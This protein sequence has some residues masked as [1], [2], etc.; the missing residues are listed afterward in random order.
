MN[1]HPNQPSLV[2]RRRI[3][4]RDTEKLTRHLDSFQQHMNPFPYNLPL[5]NPA[6]GRQLRLSRG[7]L[8]VH[9]RQAP[10]HHLPEKILLLTALGLVLLLLPLQRF[11]L[12]PEHLDLPP[13]RSALPLHAP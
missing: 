9:P 3:V 1:T 7:A 11:N 12:R 10:P 5:Q 6:T 13:Q 8:G 2:R 4:F